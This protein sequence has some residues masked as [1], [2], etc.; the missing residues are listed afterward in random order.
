MFLIDGCHLRVLSRGCRDGNGPAFMSAKGI[1]S[2]VG[3]DVPTARTGGCAVG[4]SLGT[5]V[6]P[7]RPGPERPCRLMGSDPKAGRGVYWAAV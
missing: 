1:K 3:W 2:A 7:G 6:G 5:P 4:D